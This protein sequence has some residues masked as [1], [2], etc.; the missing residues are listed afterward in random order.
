MANKTTEDIALELAQAF[1]SEGKQQETFSFTAKA[2]GDR[3]LVALVKQAKIQPSPLVKGE[4]RGS[5][6]E[7]SE[8]GA[9]GRCPMCGGTGRA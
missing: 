1:L 8:Y 7:V 4:K 9:G 6:T 3:I 2:S 5:L